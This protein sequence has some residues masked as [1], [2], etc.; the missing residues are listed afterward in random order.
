MSTRGGIM[1]LS[2]A[3]A[4]SFSEVHKAIKSKA[5]T[6]Y[7]LAGGRGSTKSSF[8]A[9]EMILGLMKDPNANAVSLRK[10]K[11]T[12]KDSTY[13]Q[14][15]WAIDILGVDNYWHK[16]I[17]PLSLTYLPTGQK[18]LFRGADK[19]KKIKSI[20]FS[21]GYCKFLWYEEL[22]EFGG[23]EEI[24]MINQSLMRGGNDF[25][26]FYSYN[27]P[28]SANNWVNAEVQLTRDD[29]LVHKS[30]YLTVPREWLGQQFILEAEELKRTKPLAYDH[31][32]LG[33][34]TGTGGEVFDNVSCR[35]ISDAEIEDFE[36]IRQGIDF[37]YAAD[38]FSYVRT[39]YNQKYKRLYIFDEV[40]Q[41]KLS[42]LAAFNLV[43]PKNKDNEMIIADSAE[44]KSI[45]EL[46]Q[47]GLR[48]KPVKKFGDSIDFGVKFLSENLEQIIIDDR[49]C[50]NTAREFLNYELERDANG[51]FKAGYPDKN[52]H[53]IDAVRYALNDECYVFK[54]D[55]EKPI[56]PN[57]A[58]G[59]FNK[60]LDDLGREVPK[61]FFQW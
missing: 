17:S 5:Y 42:N 9:I 25:V 51:N 61:E 12:L 13:E 35:T 26:V 2:T 22:D 30:D 60:M 32:Y 34:I 58:E 23:M 21:K 38:P 59:K 52:N 19:P 18:I 29:R 16:S 7:I 53:T 14:L 33:I 40:Y 28:K 20:T 24:R 50:P 3:I 56:E 31:E 46:Q 48:I 11:D 27:P 47:Y 10:V 36:V 1:R 45:N 57:S 49:R 43:M 4:P 15:S 37:G 41:V 44:P 55:K 8:V 39:A 6:H 54:F